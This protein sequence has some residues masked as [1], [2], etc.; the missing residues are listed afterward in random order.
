MRREESAILSDQEVSFE[1]KCLP[2][3]LV[4]VEHVKA[5]LLGMMDSALLLALWLEKRGGT[6]SFVEQEC[7][8]RCHLFRHL[9]M[10]L[11]FLTLMSTLHQKHQ[12]PLNM[13]EVIPVA[14]S[15]FGN[16][17]NE[18]RGGRERWNSR[19][20]FYLAAVGSAVGFGN[21]WR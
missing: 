11:C 13:S 16:E 2:R 18:E 12:E 20:G 14:R 7:S 17:S 15:S 6:E 1:K 3:S 19:I 8:D 4:E 9:I 21:V 5:S 10:F